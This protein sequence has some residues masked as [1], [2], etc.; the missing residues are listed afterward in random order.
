MIKFCVMPV[1][2]TW[3]VRIFIIASLSGHLLLCPERS[4]VVWPSELFYFILVQL[5]YPRIRA[6]V[7]EINCV[8]WL[9]LFVTFHTESADLKPRL[10]N[11]GSE[12]ICSHLAPGAKPQ[13]SHSDFSNGAINKHSPKATSV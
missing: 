13:L 7:V 8:L 6:E 12:L 1:H 4:G 11:E 5:S 2:P 10:Q 3:Y 9:Q